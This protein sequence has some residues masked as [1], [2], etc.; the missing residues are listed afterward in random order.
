M[1]VSIFKN[2]LLRYMQNQSGIKQFE[3]FAEK[4][5]SEYDLL[6]KSGF[7]TIN[8]N[9]II[10]GNTELMKTSVIFACR[11]SLQK[12]SGVHDFV[13][14]LGEATKQ[15]WINAEFIVG[16]PPLIPAIS[17]IGNILLESSIVS[18]IGTWAP[19]PPTFP[20]TDS[21]ILLDSL[22]IGIQQH[23]TTVSG[24]YFTISMY[25]SIPAPIP[26]KGVRPWTGY[27]I[28]G[29]GTPSQTSEESEPESLFVK[30]IKKI[31]NLLKNTVMDEEHIQEAEKEKQEADSVANDTSL[32]QQGR[33][34]AK[35]YSNLKKSEISTGSVNTVPVDL[36]DEE[37]NELEEN[38]PEEYKCEEGKKVLDIAKKDIGI[39]ET[40]S[41][42]GKNYGGFSGGVQKDEPGRIDEMFDNCGLDNQSKVQKTGS[43]YYWCAAAVTTWW[44]EAGL[45]LP[46]NGRAGCDFWMSWGKQNGYWSTT[47]KVG[48]AVL[49]GSSSDAHH[50]GIVAAVTK[51]GG[52][53]TIE[54]NTSGGGFSR[55]G[56]GAFRKVPK[57]YLGFVL[58]PSCVD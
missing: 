18:N 1:S 48:A 34:S 55:N 22:I 49:Y 58:P 50:I 46:P 39:L 56:C 21:N 20:N 54:G 43:G 23:L 35:E 5:T 33:A 19:Q 38:T 2:N 30:A 3:D 4:L 51:S 26:E 36:T 12:K 27:T 44:K 6:I 13:N 53:I 31:A 15:Y 52:I 40:G 11:K 14:D 57:K 37:A 42:P 10:S 24:F 9:K 25:P 45:P 17:T 28:T 41:P 16:V 47:P 8:N 7:Q 32:P 29:G